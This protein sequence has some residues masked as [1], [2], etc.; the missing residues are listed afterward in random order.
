MNGASDE[1]DILKFFSWNDPYYDHKKNQPRLSPRSGFFI[2]LSFFLAIFTFSTLAKNNLG[3]NL[4]HNLSKKCKIVS[5][6]SS[7]SEKQQST[8]GHV[9]LV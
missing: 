4:G 6:G 2:H 7:F 5:F 1:D 9:L 8:F 3:Q